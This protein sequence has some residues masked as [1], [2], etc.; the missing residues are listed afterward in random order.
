MQSFFSL[1]ILRNYL[2]RKKFAAV[3]LLLAIVSVT[4]L[5]VGSSSAQT[6]DPIF[7]ISRVA[8]SELGSNIFVLN[9]DSTISIYDAD[10]EVF[11]ISRKTIPIPFS[12]AV[13]SIIVAPSGNYFATV[14]ANNN[15][16]FLSVFETQSFISLT[17][18]KE[19]FSTIIKR[20]GNGGNFSGMF[21]CSY[22]KIV[23]LLKPTRR[24]LAI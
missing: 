8:V 9:G 2:E 12:G 16:F 18:T 21:K 7:Q 4:F 15:N 10:K 11:S 5:F 22:N 24:N 19:I 17:N 20:D 1:T 23:Y 3:F 13:F 6:L 14:A